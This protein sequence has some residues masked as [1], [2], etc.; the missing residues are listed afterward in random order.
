MNPC[1][2][3]SAHSGHTYLLPVISID[4]GH[5]KH[6]TSIK[7]LLDTGSQRSYISK[8]V[9]NN[10]GPVTNLNSHNITINTFINSSLKSFKE[11]CL[12]VDLNEGKKYPIPF[13]VHDDF[14]LNFTID[15]LT[16]AFNNISNKHMTI[17]HYDSNEVR[18][19]GLLGVDCLQYLQQ[20]NIVPCLG[21]KA[22]DLKNGIVPFGNIDSFLFSNQLAKKYAQTVSNVSHKNEQE[23]YSN[24]YN[25]NIKI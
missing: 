25:S 21:G 6:K 16:E 7:C 22:F 11:I 14:N 17:E 9:L 19:Q 20:C 1:L 12:S 23:C 4:V 2:N 13:L 3:S 15:S 8:D 5:G 24:E 18:L 10:L